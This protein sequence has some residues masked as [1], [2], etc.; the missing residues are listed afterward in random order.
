MITTQRLRIR[1]FKLADA[2]FILELLNSEGWLKYIGDRDVRTE[3]AARTYL[4]KRLMASYDEHGFGFYAVELLTSQTPIGMFGFAQRKFLDKPDLG[5]ALLP[6]YYG[7]GYAVEAAKAVLAY[8]REQLQLQ[9][10]EAFTLPTN[11]SS[12]RLLERVGFHAAGPFFLPNDEEEL[13]LMR[14]Y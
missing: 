6:A 5:F 7:Q 2:P 14:N 8:G 1:P 11:Q 3:E 4:K 10:L 9:K 12:I 13:L